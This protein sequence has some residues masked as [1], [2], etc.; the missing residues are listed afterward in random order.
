MAAREF[1]ENHAKATTVVILIVIA[2]S[3]LVSVRE[4]SHHSSFKPPENAFFTTDDGATYFTDSLSKIPPFDHGGKTAVRA[5]VV[6]SDGGA[7]RW[8]A[9]LGKYSDADQKKLESKDPKADLR[10]ML[11]K[12]P[13]AGQWIPLSSPEF[14]K[15]IAPAPPGM[16]NGP[17]EPLWP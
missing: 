4:M 2:G 12:A 6:S 16:G 1:I 15:I 7:H 9:Y 14:A 3:I 8:V 10:S 5:F 13:G 17:A 11:V